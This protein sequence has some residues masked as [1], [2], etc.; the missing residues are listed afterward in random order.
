MLAMIKTAVLVG[1]VVPDRR[2]SNTNQQGGAAGVCVPASL[3]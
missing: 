2:P 1:E 3:S